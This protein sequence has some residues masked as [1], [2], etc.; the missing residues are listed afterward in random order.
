MKND[1]PLKKEPWHGLK[2]VD[3]TSSNGKSA[4]PEVA[5]TATVAEATSNKHLDLTHNSCSKSSNIETKLL[6]DVRDKQRNH[7]GRR[8]Q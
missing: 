2:D 8:N 4:P 1:D 3:P 5:A 7:D 6:V